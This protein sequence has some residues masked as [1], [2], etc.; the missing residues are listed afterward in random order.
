MSDSWRKHSDHGQKQLQ[1]KYGNGDVCKYGDN[2]C[3]YGDNMCKYGDNVCKYVDNVLNIDY[4]TW[5]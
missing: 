2:V 3:I 4:S 5:F 1:R